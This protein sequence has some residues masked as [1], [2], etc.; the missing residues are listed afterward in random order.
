MSMSAREDPERLVARGGRRDPSHR[1]R[2]GTRRRRGS[3][4]EGR[5][6]GRL[7]RVALAV[8]VGFTSCAVA[9]I[10]G[11]AGGATAASA[12]PGINCKFGPTAISQLVL[13]VKQGE[14][15][16]I[17]CTGLPAS[18]SFL[19]IETSLL[20]AIDPA[21]EPLLTG[22]V[23]SLPGLLALISALPEMNALSEDTVSSN[24]SGVLDT[25]Y[26]VPTTQPLDPNA[27]CP[28]STEQFN[29]GLI[30]CAVAMINLSSF[31]PVT[32][33]TAVINYTGQTL[34]PPNGTLALTPSPATQ[35]KRVTISDAKNASTYWWVAT[36]ASVYTGL[37]G[38]KAGP[39][40]VVITV[41]GRKVKGAS[42]EVTPAS[43]S[44]ETFTPPKLSGS[45]IA[46]GH[47]KKTVQ[48]TLT[49]NL[50]GVGLTSTAFQKLTIFKASR[51]AGVRLTGHHHRT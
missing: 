48:V 18:T 26:T 29:S 47:G 25:T 13:N 30:G 46:P 16:T 31:A 42:G 24:S 36:L 38:G 21:A 51:V 17:D 49:A 35:G 33:G 20:V 28:P 43:Y 1:N 8:C 15:I 44:N 19:L 39:V 37:S 34:F 40:P 6:R 22:S 11:I 12:A 4:D 45:F 27:T 3:E 10:A 9:G 23:T 14:T 2:G 50:L 32:A 41:G 7:G 5:G